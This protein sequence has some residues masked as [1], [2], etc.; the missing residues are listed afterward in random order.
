MEAPP[1]VGDDRRE[2]DVFAPSTLML[3][4]AVYEA[5]LANLLAHAVKSPGTLQRLRRTI[6][7]ALRDFHARR[8]VDEERLPPEFRYWPQ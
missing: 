2:R 8:R 3:D 1:S 7:S 5:A 4:D 6:W